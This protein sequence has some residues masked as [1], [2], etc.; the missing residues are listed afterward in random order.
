M[1]GDYPVRKLKM[2][3]QKPLARE[4]GQAIEKACYSFLLKQNI[5]I[6]S[7]NFYSKMGE[8]DLI[9]Y[10]HNILI[11][12]E[13]RYRNKTNYGSS[14]DSVT[15]KKQEKIYK[16]ALFFLQKH[17]EF[18]EHNYRFDIIGASTYNGEIQFQWQKN[19]FQVSESWI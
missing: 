2:E 1:R 8:I 18:K 16:T 13:V 19:A 5:S 7:A 17:P 11:F 4:Q 3:K 10:D 15:K 9:G 14:F 12:F 6:I